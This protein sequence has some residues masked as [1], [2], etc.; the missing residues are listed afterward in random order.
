MTGMNG[1]QPGLYQFIQTSFIK[2]QNSDPL[3][4]QWDNIPFS[5]VCKSYRCVRLM[6][7]TNRSIGLS[8]FFG[9]YGNIQR[10]ITRKKPMMHASQGS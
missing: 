8:C 5:E 6:S 3:E 7:K 4:P 10:N 2:C 1:E 9:Y